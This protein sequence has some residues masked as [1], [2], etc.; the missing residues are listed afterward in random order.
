MNEV[1]RA[2]VAELRT[3]AARMDKRV[4]T[5]TKVGR[6]GPKAISELSKAVVAV[7]KAIAL[8]LFAYIEEGDGATD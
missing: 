1:L 4:K 5:A 8:D 2:L 3:G 6:H 7:R